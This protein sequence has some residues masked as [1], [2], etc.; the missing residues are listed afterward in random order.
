MIVVVESSF[1]PT[2]KVLVD[3]GF[4]IVFVR[5]ESYLKLYQIFN[6]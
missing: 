4:T 3:D 6:P 2:V 5:K 1:L